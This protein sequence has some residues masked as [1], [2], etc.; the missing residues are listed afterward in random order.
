MTPAPV[1][2]IGGSRGTGLLIARLLLQHGKAVRVLARDPIA[3]GSRLGS[4]GD[5][6]RG[7]LTDP[8]SLASAMRGVAHIVFTAGVRSGRLVRERTVRRIEFEG[9]L[10]TIEATRASGFTGRFLYMNSS[11][12][13]SRSF[14]ARALNFYKGNTLEWRARAEAAIRNSQLAYAIIRTGVLLNSRGGRHEIGLTQKPLPLSPKYRIARADVAEVF[15]AA[16]DH[17]KV[18]RTTFEIA[19]QGRPELRWRDALDTLKPDSA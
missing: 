14:W 1:L 8:E 4:S 3:A 17:P 11:G 16:L 18:V 5:I 9:M 15:A 19:W 10:N 2:V 13:G 12:T 7:D 6:V